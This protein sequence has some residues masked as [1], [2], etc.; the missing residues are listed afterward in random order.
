M[1]DTSSS[2]RSVG[3]GGGVGG[4]FSIGS[5]EASEEGTACADRRMGDVASVE[6]LVGANPSGTMRAS[7]GGAT[8]KTSTGSMGGHSLIIGEEADGKLRDGGCRAAPGGLMATSAFSC[9]EALAENAP[10]PSDISR[11]V[12]ADSAS[13]RSVALFSSYAQSKVSKALRELGEIASHL[14]CSAE[15]IFYKVASCSFVVRQSATIKQCLLHHAGRSSP[16]FWHRC[17]A[18]KDCLRARSI[19]HMN[20]RVST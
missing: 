19:I 18:N 7:E 9:T 17:S 1:Y 8:V 5:K 13:L 6:R 2:N 11:R 20:K 14:E 15:L 10:E 3:T 4:S 12:F 16:I